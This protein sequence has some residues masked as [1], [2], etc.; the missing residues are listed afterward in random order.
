MT[1]CICQ[2]VSSQEAD[3][4]LTAHKYFTILCCGIMNFSL[5]SSRQ[6][7]EC[8]IFMLLVWEWICTLCRVT[9]TM[10]NPIVQR[11]S[12]AEGRDGDITTDSRRILNL[13]LCFPYFLSNWCLIF[14]FVSS[15]LALTPILLNA[16]FLLLLSSWILWIS[17]PWKFR[18]SSPSRVTHERRGYSFVR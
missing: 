9:G 14:S 17:T 2:K 7:N 11:S 6:L 1:H 4:Q 8:F 13:L 15:T 18:Y 3:N 5:R 16:L 10:G 12:S